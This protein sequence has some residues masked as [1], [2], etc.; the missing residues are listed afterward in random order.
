MRPSFF[1][2][3]TLFAAVAVAALDCKRSDDSAAAVSGTVRVIANEKGYTP[4]SVT[5]IKGA[6]V[7]LEFV[8]TT[9]D[10]CAREVVVPALHI[11]EP[12]PLNTPVA[13]RLPT[14]EARTFAFACGMGMF[15]GEV[16]IR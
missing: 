3:S 8:R 5:V 7:T 2:T 16:V 12:L 1:A 6:P 4:S 11:T 13:I 14:D 15:K 10:T 9:D